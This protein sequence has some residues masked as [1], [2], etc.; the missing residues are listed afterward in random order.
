MAGAVA[1][2][3]CSQSY[4]EDWPQRPLEIMVIAAPGGL[5]DVTAR[6]VATEEVRASF[7]RQGLEASTMSPQEPGACIKSETEKW[8]SVLKN[9][10]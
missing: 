4:A 1:L 5:S 9:A 7:E 6:L 10:R 2:A 8:A 3:A